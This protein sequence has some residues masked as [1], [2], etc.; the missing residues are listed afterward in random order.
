MKKNQSGFTLIELMIVVAII[1][2]LAAIALPA[3]QDYTI[4]ARVSEGLLSTT[5]C[6]TTVAEVYQTAQSG[7]TV[8]QDAWGCGEGN[9]PTK[10][11]SQISTGANSGI[12]TVKLRNIDPAVDTKTITLT[13]EDSAGNPLDNGDFPTQVFHFDCDPGDISAQYVPGSCR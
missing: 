4:K 1:G 3:Y 8:L 9:N 2:I 10:Y 7:D 12:I 6:R 11:V 13:P 5:Q